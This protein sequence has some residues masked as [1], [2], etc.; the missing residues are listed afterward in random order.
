[1]ISVKESE[2]LRKCKNCLT[3]LEF[4]GQIMVQNSLGRWKC[5]KC[6]KD[7]LWVLH[8]EWGGG[9]NQL[10]KVPGG[11]YSVVSM[12]SDPD[13]KVFAPLRGS[14]RNNPIKEQTFYSAGVEREKGSYGMFAGPNPDIQEVL[15]SSIP[16]DAKNN[17]MPVY[18]MDQFGN[19]THRWHHGRCEWVD[20]KK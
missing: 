13:C 18:V 15:N 4:T 1:M 10:H 12:M 8:P 17:L 9:P 6:G 2:A 7:W 16:D 14:R 11:G 3:P 5:P 20:L 19:T